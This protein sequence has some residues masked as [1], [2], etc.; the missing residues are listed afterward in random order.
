MYVNQV[1]LHRMQKTVGYLKENYGACVNLCGEDDDVVTLP[2]KR[3]LDD[4]EAVLSYLERA[5]D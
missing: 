4:A 5:H 1:I 2:A 3:A